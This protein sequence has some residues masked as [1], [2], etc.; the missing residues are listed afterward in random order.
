MIRSATLNGVPKPPRLWQEKFASSKC[1][2]ARMEKELTLAEF[3][4][5]TPTRLMSKVMLEEI[6]FDTWHGGC[7]IL[8]GDGKCA[9]FCSLED[10]R[11]Q[12]LTCLEHHHVDACVLISSVP[13]SKSI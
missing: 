5:K 8:L 3:V 6:V 1:L 11:V 12:K 2:V 10:S 13:Q 4:D 7:T 9:C